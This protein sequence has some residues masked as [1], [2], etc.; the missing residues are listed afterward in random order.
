MM[1]PTPKRPRHS[2]PGGG[3]ASGEGQLLASVELARWWRAKQRDPETFMDAELAPLLARQSAAGRISRFTPRG[4]FSDFSGGGHPT[5][6]SGELVPTNNPH[7][8]LLRVGRTRA[9][10]SMLR[11]RAD[12]HRR[13]GERLALAS[14]LLWLHDA[15]GAVAVLE[16]VEE[17]GNRA[18]LLLDVA[19]RQSA[20]D[21]QLASALASGAARRSVSGHDGG[22]SWQPVEVRDLAS[23]GVGEFH[24]DFVRAGRPVVLR[25]GADAMVG[26]V[27]QRWSLEMLSRVAG[28][29]RVHPKRRVDDSAAWARL[30]PLSG[31]TFMVVWCS[32]RP[33]LTGVGLGRP[34][35]WSRSFFQCETSAGTVDGGRG[36]AMRDFIDAVSAH[37]AQQPAAPRAALGGLDGESSRRRG[38]TTS[39]P[40]Y[41]FDCARAVSVVCMASFD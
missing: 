41:L 8:L 31:G 4:C 6:S 38:G 34:C 11:E 30:E 29:A 16:A 33:N 37:A 3:S 17:P 40:G 14:C 1:P 12:G 10:Q 9:A 15:A 2:P 36:C 25:G 18:R 27:S 35:S 21:A 32:R 23:L 26:G 20:A 39:D 22:W 19:R 5:S 24:R 28:G 7:T 13:R